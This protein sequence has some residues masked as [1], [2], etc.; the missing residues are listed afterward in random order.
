VFVCPQAFL[1]FPPH[2]AV[3]QLEQVVT[4]KWQNEY[5]LSRLHGAMT[6]FDYSV[7]NIEYLNRCGLPRE[8]LCHLPIDFNPD[9]RQESS[10][11]DFD[12]VF[13]GDPTAPR[14]QRIL[15]ALKKR[16][17]VQVISNV[18]GDELYRML[19]RAKVLVN[20][21]FYENALLET[22][23]LYEALSLGGPMIVSE[24]SCDS[25]EDKRVEDFIDFVDVDDCD[26]MS[27]RIAYW[28]SDENRR[29]QAVDQN[30]AR[31]SKRE[32]AFETAMNCYFS[33]RMNGEML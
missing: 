17:D 8:R 26:A 15:A 31:L 12:V 18:F 7:N 20:I 4:E 2:Y 24:R 22:T 19:A 30:Y 28:L 32:N 23:R 5:Y 11:H 10:L 27:T 13:Y 14:R 25:G 6:V 3:M 9:M 16:F 33:K 21:H 1:R 29:R